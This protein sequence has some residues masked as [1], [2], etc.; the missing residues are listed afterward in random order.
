VNVSGRRTPARLPTKEQLFN[1]FRSFGS[2]KLVVAGLGL[3][4]TLGVATDASAAA[5]NPP[6][7]ER[8]DGGGNVALV[9]AAQQTR[10]L[11]FSMATTKPLTAKEQRWM[12]KEMAL[13]DDEM[14][15]TGDL[16]DLFT[17]AGDDPYLMFDPAWNAKVE[18]VLHVFV[19]VDHKQHALRAPTRRTRSIDRQFDKMFGEASVAGSDLRLFLT[20]YDSDYADSAGTHLTNAGKAAHKG[21]VLIGRL[22]G[23]DTT[24]DSMDNT[25]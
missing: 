4:V 19:V 3:M 23:N 17:E 7:L 18:A 16:Q 6:Q 2:A 15:A 24:L 14:D 13:L 22:K 12:T 20:T 8:P 25:L 21:T 11:P 1:G 9:I 10:I 5:R